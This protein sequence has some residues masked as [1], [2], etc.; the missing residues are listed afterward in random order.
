VQKKERKDE[1]KGKERRNIE[2]VKERKN[3]YGLR[4]VKGEKMVDR[5]DGRR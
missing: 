3:K 4:N 1:R 5:R 2:F